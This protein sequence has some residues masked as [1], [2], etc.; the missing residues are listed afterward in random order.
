MIKH[1]DKLDRARKQKGLQ[2]LYRDEDL[3][4]TMDTSEHVTQG[5]NAPT[6]AIGQ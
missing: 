4:S 3:P 2:A 1:M 6:P 5:H